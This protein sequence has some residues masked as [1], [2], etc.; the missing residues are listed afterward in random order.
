MERGALLLKYVVIPCDR[1]AGE[2]T[3]TDGQ[4]D[5]QTDRQQ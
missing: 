4:I 3:E 1:N 2:R 5:I